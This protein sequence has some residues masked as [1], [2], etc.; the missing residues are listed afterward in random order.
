M[1]TKKSVKKFMTKKSVRALRGEK[2]DKCV[3]II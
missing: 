2:I 3:Q 1:P